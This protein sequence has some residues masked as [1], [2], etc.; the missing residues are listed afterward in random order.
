MRKW[1]PPTR[2]QLSQAHQ[3]VTYRRYRCTGQHCDCEV[4]AIERVHVECSTPECRGRMKPRRIV[5]TAKVV[6]LQVER[7]RRRSEPE[8]CPVEGPFSGAFRPQTGRNANDDRGHSGED[9]NASDGEKRGGRLPTGDSPV[10]Q[11]EGCS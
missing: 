11:D 2:R 8:N 10:G 5:P 7:L 4:I 3:G 9:F 1:F 6:D